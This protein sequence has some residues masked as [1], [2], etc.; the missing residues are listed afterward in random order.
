MYIWPFPKHQEPVSYKKGVPYNYKIMYK[1][2]L[3]VPSK[4]NAIHTFLCYRF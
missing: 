3:I 1:E 4:P 2:N